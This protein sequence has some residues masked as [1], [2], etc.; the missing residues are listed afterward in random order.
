MPEFAE[1]RKQHPE[2]VIKAEDGTKHMH[3]QEVLGRARTMPPGSGEEQVTVRT[4]ELA[5]GMVTCA[6]EK[7]RD[8]KLATAD[9]LNSQEG[10]KYLALNL[11]AHERTNEGHH[12][13][14]R[15]V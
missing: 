15:L 4:L 10:T 12:G 5:R 2:R 13:Y 6:L 14:E 8:P 1:W 3:T 11:D 9:K 7:M